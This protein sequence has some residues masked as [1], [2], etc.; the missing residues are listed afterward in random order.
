MPAVVPAFAQWTIQNTGTNAPLFSLSQLGDQWLAGSVGAVLYSDNNGASWEERELRDPISNLPIAAGVRCTKLLGP[1]SGIV[2]GTFFLGNTQMVAASNDAFQSLGIIPINSGGG[3]PRLLNDWSFPQ[4]GTGFACGS[5]YSLVKTTDNGQSWTLANN[6]GIEL[7]GIDFFDETHGIAVGAY[8]ALRTENGGDNWQILPAPTVFLDVSMASANVVFAVSENQLYRSTD[9]GQNWISAGLPPLLSLKCVESLDEHRVLV[10]TTFGIYKVEEDG[11]AWSFFPET[12]IELPNFNYVGINQLYRSGNSWRAA[13]DFGYLMSGSETAPATPLALAQSSWSG[14]GCDTFF[15]HASAFAGS[16]WTVAWWLGDQLVSNASQLDLVFTQTVADTL[17][18]I[19]GNGVAADTAFWPI[20]SE[21]FVEKPEI[22]P[23]LM[24]TCSGNPLQFHPPGNVQV[25]LWEPPALFADASAQDAIFIGSN[26]ATIAVAFYYEG[27]LG[28]DTVE[29]DILDDYPTE[30][31]HPTVQGA[32]H[33]KYIID[34]VDGQHGF[35]VE[36]N[37][38]KFIRTTDGALSWSD[39][40]TFFNPNASTASIDFVD[41][42]TGY[43]S[44]GQGVFRTIDG[45]QSWSPVSFQSGLNNLHFFDESTGI[46]SGPGLAPLS[47]QLYATTNA[48]QN[49]TPGYSGIGQLAGIKCRQPDDCYCLGY[50]GAQ[51]IVLRSSD[52]GNNWQSTAFSELIPFISFDFLGPDS[53]IAMGF[54]GDLYFS[55]DGGASWSDPKWMILPGGS[56]NAAEAVIGMA[57]GKEG[58]LSLNFDLLKTFDGGQCWYKLSAAETGGYTA[59]DF[60]FPDSTHWYF[61]SPLAFDLLAPGQIFRLD[62]VPLAPSGTI[63]AVGPSSVFW[64]S[65]NPVSVGQMLRIPLAGDWQIVDLSGRL[66]CTGGHVEA[67]ESIPVL[68]PPGLYLLSLRQKEQVWTYK[69]MVA[70]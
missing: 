67:D 2:S 28:A 49:W 1:Q 61:A 46:A 29:I 47:F 58:Y 52:Q 11:L 40:H 70:P 31:W 42:S 56:V 33:L 44:I 55:Y 50:N 21:V 48:G 32:N 6:S 27:C 23:P 37:G 4:P 65:P 22:L 34:F 60:A 17:W 57:N 63:S 3:Y 5:N 66:I 69:L 9:G 45:G 68:L 18:L 64:P 15:Y 26:D 41:T 35:A 62:S 14:G 54:S 20:A 19:V 16:T 7:F 43:V 39:P 51:S 38:D 53:L 36:K 59:S 10:G 30:Y 8:A 12:Q 13:C 25:F 24:E